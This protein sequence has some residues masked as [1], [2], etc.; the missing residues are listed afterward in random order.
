MNGHSDSL[1][2]LGSVCWADATLE[3]IT[4]D[5]ET[6]TV[7]IREP[8]GAYVRVDCSGY[9]G[10]EMVGFWDEIIIERAELLYE[11]EF[12]DRCAASIRG[13]LGD[14]L[15]PTGSPARNAGSLALLQIT[16]IDGCQLRVALNDLRLTR[17]A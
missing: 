17:A 10:I 2:D 5:Y 7:A 3:A 13:R 11:H 9:V 12:L 14:K 15:L 4:V 8:L 1:Q 16:F 6:A